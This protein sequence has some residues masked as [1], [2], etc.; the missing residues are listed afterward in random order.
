M[1]N[2]MQAET[3]ATVAQLIR[4]DLKTVFPGVKFSVTTRRG[5]GSVTVQWVDGPAVDPVASI[6]AK[7]EAGSFNG[8]TDSYEFRKDRPAHP[9]CQFTFASRSIS[10]ALRTRAERD[11]AAK[12]GGTSVQIMD[13]AYQAF[14]RADL[15]PGYAGVAFINGRCEIVTGP[16]AETIAVASPEV[17]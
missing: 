17:A 13:M 5:T 12:F 4:A 8:M 7:Y 15:R 10:D 16:A 6:A 1:T 9:T 11:I 14:R 3:S 2:A